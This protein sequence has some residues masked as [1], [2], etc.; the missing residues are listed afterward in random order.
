MENAPV[1][2]P[3]VALVGRPN[4]GKSTLFNQLTRTRDALVADEAGLTRDRQY[5]LADVAEGHCIVVD[6]GGIMEQAEGLDAS[7][8]EQSR[9]AIEEADFVLFL[10]DGRAGVLSEDQ[11]I[12]EMLR[13]HAAKTCLVMNKCEGLERDVLAAE[14]FALGL[15]DP[16][17]IAAAHGQGMGQ[18]RELLAQ[19][20]RLAPNTKPRRE[21]GRVAVA[22]VGRPN[23]GK[24]TLLN[25]LVGENRVIA[26]DVA[27]TT[28]DSVEVAFEYNGKPYTLIDTAGLRRK[29]KVYDRIEKFSVVK[30]LQAIEAANV[31]VA[32]IDA[33]EGIGAQDARILGMVAESGRAIVVAINKWDGLEEEQRAQIK[34]EVERKLPFLDYASFVSISALHGSRLKELMQAVGKAHR[35]AFCDLSTSA[36]SAVLEKAVHAHPPP[37]VAGR[38]IKLRYAHQGGRNPP[39]IVIH[40]NQTEKL[41]NNYRRYLVNAFRQAFE[42]DGTPVHLQFKTSDNPYKDRKN[43]LSTGQRRKRDR[44][45]R[46]RIKSKKS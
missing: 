20:V 38:R 14:F 41:N 1:V 15:G 46:H 24:S 44:M 37:A 26:S 27:G 32:L 34:S 2:A 43:E 39:T 35:A 10:V 6:T 19:R 45:I 9:L 3:T 18:L 12:A 42:L 23:A 4:V 30:T 25:R 7:V 8:A 29:A 17:G 22:L 28:R 33:R 21:H 40:G 36:L 31:V 5:G 11:A 13:P 16:L